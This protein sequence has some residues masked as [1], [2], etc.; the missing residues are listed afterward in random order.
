MRSF[1]FTVLS[2]L[3]LQ[4]YALGQMEYRT[5]LGYVQRGCGTSTF[6]TRFYFANAAEITRK[7]LIIT[8]IACG[9]FFQVVFI[10]MVSA[11]FLKTTFKLF[12][13]KTFTYSY[14]LYGTFWGVSTTALGLLGMFY[15]IYAD[16]A[17]LY[18]SMVKGI[19]NRYTLLPVVLLATLVLELPVAIY[20]TRKATVAVPCIFK[21]PANVLCC[22]RMRRAECLVTTLAL[23]IILT[24]LQLVLL[25]GTLFV[26]TI[27]VEP[28]GIA[29]NA[30]L[31]VLALSCLTNIFSLL[32]TIFA[33]L[34]TPTH[35][36]VASSSMVFRAVVVLPMLLAIICYGVVVT[37]LGS[38]I[39][40]DAKQNNPL[41]FI[42]SLAIPLTL[43][44]I[45][46]FLK[47]F[48]SAWLKWAPEERENGAVTS[49]TQE[50]DEELLDP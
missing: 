21:Y 11:V 50:V 39:N 43:G 6:D 31:L 18:F 23:W 28:F 27:S 2:V 14:D 42:N 24:A 36:R 41:S 33:H 16:T 45:S 8:L 1:I 7:H 34:F 3:Q 37:S 4:D 15:G 46:I 25:H 17:F 40:V 20:I 44:V 5:N 22:G 9:F 30:M 29:T 10:W 48:I 19:S 35:Q 13:Q 49:H 26:L 32:F 38:V 12:A 47:R